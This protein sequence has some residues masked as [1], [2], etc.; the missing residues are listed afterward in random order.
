MCVYKY[1][2]LQ[3][4]MVDTAGNL[5]LL[6]KQT[7]SDYFSITPFPESMIPYLHFV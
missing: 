1:T 3:P 4:M 2:E 7:L 6:E 5:Q